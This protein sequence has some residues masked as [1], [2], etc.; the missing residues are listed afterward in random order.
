M[1]VVAAPPAKTSEERS[2]RIYVRT[3][4]P[5]ASVVLDGKEL[6]T[7]DGLFLVP[8]GVRKITLEMEGYDPESKAVEVKEGWITRVEVR[9]E[10]SGGKAGGG[11]A[12]LSEDKI[13]EIKWTACPGQGEAE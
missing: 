4:P 6:G 3:T 2:T 13:D 11:K 7:S 1:A 8:P 5:G 12:T 10:R 9:M